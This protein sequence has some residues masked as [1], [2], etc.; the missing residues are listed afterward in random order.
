MVRDMGRVDQK[1]D[2]WF[3]QDMVADLVL[4]CISVLGLILVV[5]TLYYLANTVKDVKGRD[6][7]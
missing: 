6:F 1:E 2:V 4:L 3:P 7:F 5:L